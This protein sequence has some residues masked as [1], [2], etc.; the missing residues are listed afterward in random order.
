MMTGTPLRRW[1]AKILYPGKE[2][3]FFGTLH[4]RPDAPLEEI[5]ETMIQLIDRHLPAGFQIFDLV[6]GAIWFTSEEEEA[7]RD[8]GRSPAA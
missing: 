3:I 2:P 8:A 5:R 6:P 7:P 1:C 4:I